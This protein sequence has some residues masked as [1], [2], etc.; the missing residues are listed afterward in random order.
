VS[1]RH[2]IECGGIGG[3]HSYGCPETPEPPEDDTSDDLDDENAANRQEQ[4]PFDAI[5]EIMGHFIDGYRQLK[6]SQC[7]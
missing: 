3:H 5:A 7:N 2:C 1:R 4:P 6:H